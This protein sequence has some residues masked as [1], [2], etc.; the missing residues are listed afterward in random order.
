[1]EE[2]ESE[3][4]LPELPQDT[5]AFAALADL[6]GLRLQ[7]QGMTT[8]FDRM[9]DTYDM[10]L[11]SKDHSLRVRQKLDNMYA[12]NE[13]RLTYKFPLREHE[14]LFIRREKKLTVEQADYDKVLDLLSSLVAGVTDDPLSAILHVNELAR[15]AYIGEEGARLSL[16]LDHCSYSLPDNEESA[17]DEYVFE[18]ETHGLP[19][20]AVLQAADW[21]L[22]NLG[23]REAK[24]HK[25]AR[26]MR[27]VGNL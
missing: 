15:E 2:I 8:T 19:E 26:G 1:M 21:V 12:G 14:R 24:Q 18:I 3:I 6:L 10:A 17:R 7:P 13:I 11:L 16:S 5:R 9:V 27:L 23:G 4:T 20:D 22:E 25:Y